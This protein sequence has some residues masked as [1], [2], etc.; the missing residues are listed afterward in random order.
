MIDVWSVGCV[1]LEM[2]QGIPLFIGESS[3]DHLIEII[4]VMGT[5]TKTQVIDMN[6]EYDLN[7]YKFPK[8]KKK[9]WSKVI[10]FLF[11]IFPKVDHTLLDLISQ[12]MIYSPNQR[13]TAAEALCH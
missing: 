5:P 2:I 3:I 13:L 7:D 12:I 6:P 9:D 4:K 1:I 10:Y 11:Q 8:I